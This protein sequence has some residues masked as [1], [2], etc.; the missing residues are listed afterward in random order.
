VCG[1]HG[2]ADE[3]RS[4]RR[5]QAATVSLDTVAGL[6]VDLLE[7]LAGALDGASE[8]QQVVV[9]VGDRAG[10][11][12]G[13]VRAEPGDK[14]DL[15]EVAWAAERVAVAER[16][17]RRGGAAHDHGVVAAVDGD[18]GGVI[19]IRAA[20]HCAVAIAELRGAGF[21]PDV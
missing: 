2:C 10:A 15:V 5:G 19:I 14:G 13:R 4:L 7:A 21:C 16:E 1:E 9:A 11:G 6:V 3:A 18:A 8:A 12:G 17:V 20:Q